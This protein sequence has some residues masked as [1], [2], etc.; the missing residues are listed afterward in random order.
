M[1]F[2][3]S[4]PSRIFSVSLKTALSCQAAGIFLPLLPLGWFFPPQPVSPPARSPSAVMYERA[5]EGPLATD[6]AAVMDGLG[7]GF[8]VAPGLLEL[9]LHD[10][11][12]VRGAALS[13]AHFG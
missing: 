10:A 4:H 13:K 5:S 6:R 7:A 8:P 3:I 1:N 9:C 12:A 2:Y 11:G